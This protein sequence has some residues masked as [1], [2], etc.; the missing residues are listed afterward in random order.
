[1]PNK[2]GRTIAAVCGGAAV[3]ALALGGVGEVGDAVVPKTIADP[4]TTVAPTPGSPDD[5]CCDSPQPQASA[6]W[7]CKIG[8]NC[9][10]I[11]PQR[12]LPAPPPPPPPP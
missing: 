10:P 8:L 12:T 11:R 7:N 5:Q 1:M 3:L 2:A 6:S 9:G 4:P